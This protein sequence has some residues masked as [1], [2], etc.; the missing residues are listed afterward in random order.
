ML[1]VI[2]FDHFEIVYE[3]AAG[4]EKRLVTATVPQILRESLVD[5]G[6]GDSAIRTITFFVTIII[7]KPGDHP[8]EPFRRFGEVEITVAEA[9][10]LT[11]RWIEGARDNAVPEID[12]FIKEKYRELPK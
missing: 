12:A 10:G 5:L 7:E 6:D 11:D 2:Q 3:D 9:A 1:N 8:F 4:D